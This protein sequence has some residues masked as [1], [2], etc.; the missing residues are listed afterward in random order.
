MGFSMEIETYEGN[1]SAFLQNLLPTLPDGAMQLDS[2][3]RGVE[4]VYGPVV[5]G[6]DFIDYKPSS[7]GKERVCTPFRQI[8]KLFYMK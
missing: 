6:E 1:L 4:K 3:A 8:K 7:E 2:L 5:V